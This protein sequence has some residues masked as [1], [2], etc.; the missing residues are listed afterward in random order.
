[1]CLVSIVVPIYNVEKYLEKC[2]DSILMQS[3]SNI[4]VLLI[5]DG[6][7]DNSE[8]ICKKYAQLDKRIQYFK[9]EN[10]GLSSAR[11]YGIDHASGD[12]LIFV[13][14]DDYISKEMVKCLLE[15]ALSQD[16]DIVECNYIEFNEDEILFDDNYSN[17]VDVKVFQPVEAIESLIRNIAITPNAWNKIYSKKL[18]DQLRYKVGI[19]HEDEE[20][21]VKLLSISSKVCKIDVPLYY[22]LKR[23]GSIMNSQLNKKHLDIIDIMNDRIE[24][25]HNLNINSRIIDLSIIR[26]SNICNELYARMCLSNTSFELEKKELDILRNRIIRYVLNSDTPLIKRLKAVQYYLFPKLTYKLKYIKKGG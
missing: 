2:I 8:Y 26:Y 15:T 4:E 1:M 6:S 24:S 21:I 19:Y 13:D 3:Y 20:I 9:K 17:Q 12:Y 25:L 11:N 16:A 23:S 7:K 10:G 14:S 22:Y 18:F 5:N